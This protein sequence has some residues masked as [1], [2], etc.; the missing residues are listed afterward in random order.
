MANELT[1]RQEKVLA[2]MRSYAKQNGGRCPTHRDIAKEL[3]CAYHTGSRCHLEALER[4]GYL[5]R[6][7]FNKRYLALVEEAK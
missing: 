6:V 5:K 7:G 2:F 4:K 3:D 1:K